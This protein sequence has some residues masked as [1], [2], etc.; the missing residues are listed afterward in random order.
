MHECI[1]KF[2]MQIIILLMNSNFCLIIL[3]VIVRYQAKIILKIIILFNKIL[4]I[5]VARMI[6]YKIWLLFTPDKNYRDAKP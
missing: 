4:Y 5:T 2:R 6:V 3:I 1:I